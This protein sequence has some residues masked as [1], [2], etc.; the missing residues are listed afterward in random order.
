LN[1]ALC[2]CVYVGVFSTVAPV[3]WTQ[4]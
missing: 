1:I 4:F 2:V 3:Y